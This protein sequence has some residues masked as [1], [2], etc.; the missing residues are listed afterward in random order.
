MME[1]I[2]ALIEKIRGNEEH[3]HDLADTLLQVGTRL[4]AL[5]SAV[6]GLVKLEE[7]KAGIT[8]EAPAAPGAGAAQQVETAPQA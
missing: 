2:N 6:E 8:G 4:T 5:E 1:R 7:A 3:R